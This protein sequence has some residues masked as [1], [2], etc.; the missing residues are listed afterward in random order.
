MALLFQRFTNLQKFRDT[1]DP[2]C[3]SGLRRLHFVRCALR[4]WQSSDGGWF[5][6]AQQTSEAREEGRSATVGN[7]LKWGCLGTVGLFVLIF[8][9]GIAALLLPPQSPNGQNQRE[10]PKRCSEQ[11]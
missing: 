9:M 8:V 2:A 5:N 11:T 4:K 3:W 7:I 6:V 1:A 10:S